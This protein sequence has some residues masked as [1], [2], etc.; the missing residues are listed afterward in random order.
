MDKL[1]N[2]ENSVLLEKFK[3]RPKRGTTASEMCRRAGTIKYLLKH[4]VNDNRKFHSCMK[5][6]ISVLQKH[7][8][9]RY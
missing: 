8:E 1:I 7:P 2:V 5:D 6:T 9:R 4:C 3:K